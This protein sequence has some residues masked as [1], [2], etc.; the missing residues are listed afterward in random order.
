MYDLSSA[1]SKEG[2]IRKHDRHTRFSGLEHINQLTDERLHVFLAE[3]RWAMAPM[4]KPHR[5][6]ESE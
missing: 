4:N 2:I 6:N 3:I 5:I 1:H